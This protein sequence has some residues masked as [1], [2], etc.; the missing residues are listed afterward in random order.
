MLAPVVDG[1]FAKTMLV[2][3]TITA[4]ESEDVII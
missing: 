4:K 3:N 2:V 1:Q